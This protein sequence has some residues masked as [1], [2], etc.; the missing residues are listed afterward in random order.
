MRSACAAGP[1]CTIS[2]ARL[3]RALAGVP[4]PWAADGRLVLV[5]DV[6]PWLRPDANTWADRA[7]CHTFGGGGQAS[8]GRTRW[9]LRWRPAARPGRRR[10]E[11]SRLMSFTSLQKTA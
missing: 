5:V 11:D 10:G 2:V 9:W 7:F 3:R 8:A 6:S 4:L 1:A